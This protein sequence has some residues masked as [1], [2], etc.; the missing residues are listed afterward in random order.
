MSPILII[1]VAG[2]FGILALQGFWHARGELTEQRFAIFQIAPLTII[3][4]TAGL[5]AYLSSPQP[6][7]FGLLAMSIG[8]II[9]AVIGYPIARWVY[10][11]IFPPK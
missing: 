1:E 6:Y 7:P 2:Y 3:I 10:R 11:Q 5:D 8:T 9:F 4:M